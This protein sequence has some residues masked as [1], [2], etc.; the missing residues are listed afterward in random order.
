MRWQSGV[1][2]A[3]QV[4]EGSVA[5]RVKKSSNRLAAMVAVALLVALLSAISGYAAKPVPVHGGPYVGTRAETITLDGSGSTADPGRTIVE[6]KWKVDGAEVYKGPHPTYDLVLSGYSLGDHGVKLEV[7]DNNGEKKDATTTLTVNNAPPVAE[8][9]GPYSGTQADTATLDSAGSTDPDGTIVNYEWKID[10]NQVYSGSNPTYGLDLGGYSKGGHTVTLIVTDDDGTTD[11][12]TAT[13]TV[14]NGPPVANDDSDTTPEDTPATTNVVTNDTDVDGTVVASTVAIVSGPSNGSVVS[15]G[16]GTV[17]Y[18][19]NENFNGSDAYTYT[20]QDN[21]GATSN[22]ATMTITVGP[23]NDAPVAQDD[24]YSTNEDTQLNITAPGVL[25]NDS[26]V[27]G[28]SPTA[29]LDTT[30][31]NGTLTLNN[32]GSFTYAPNS[33]FDATDTFTYHASD[34]TADSNVATVAI[35]VEPSNDLP[36]ANDDSDTTPEDTPVTTNVVA[37]DT[38]VDGTVVASTVAIA[39]G[40]SNG[41]VVNNGDGTVTYTPNTNFTG[42]DAYTYTLRDNNGVPSNAAT[43]TITVGPVND[44]PI[45]NDDMVLTNEDTPLPIEVTLNDNDL[46]GT[47]DPATIMIDDAPVSGAVQVAGDGTVTYTPDPDFS[48]I[49]LFTYTV[50]D[51]QGAAS[52][53]AMVMVT[54]VEGNDPPIAE[55]DLATTDAGV[56]VSIAVLAND[57]DPDGSLNPGIVTTVSEPK[58]G[59]T[60]VNPDGT[61]T[62]ISVAGFVG[63]D[64]FTYRVEDAHQAIS[65]EATVTVEI[66]EMIGGGGTE[67]PVQEVMPSVRFIKRDTNGI[68]SFVLSEPEEEEGSYYIHILTVD[69]TVLEELALSADIQPAEIRAG[70]PLEVGLE[71]SE[72]ERR[73]R[74]W[75]WIRVTRPDLDESAGGGGAAGAGYSFSGRHVNDLYWLEIDTS[76]LPPGRYNFWIIYG[77]G[78]T[79]LVPSLIRNNDGAPSNVTTVAK[80]V[81]SV[82][83]TPIAYDDT[84]LTDE[85]TSLP[86]QVTLNDDD[87]DGTIDPATIIIADAPVSGTVQVA[88]DGTITYS[89]NADFSG[90]DQFTYTVKDN[91]GATSNVAMVMVTVVGVN[92]SPI[93]EDDLATTK[94]GVPVSIAVLSNDSDPDSSLVP[95]TVTTLSE[96]ESGT[97]TVNWD[98]TITYTSVEGFVGTDQFT[99]RVEDAHDAISNEA[100]VTVEV[101]EVTG[102]GG[103]ELAVQEPISSVGFLNND[104]DDISSLVLS[105]PKNEEASYH[106]HILTVDS[107]VLEELALSADI[108]PTEIRAGAPLEVGL[109]F[110]EEERRTRGWPWIRVT[111]PDLA[112]SVGGGGTAAAGYAFSGRFANGLYWLEI[113]TSDLTLGRYNFWIVYGEG[114]TLLVPIL[115]L[116]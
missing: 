109:E 35:T 85:N 42:S 46:D 45:A 44:T 61:I 23:V 92:A 95:E 13:L 96:P 14:E 106:I 27:D 2:F 37:N 100:A 15:N 38:D 69:S 16:D 54:V 41:S 110:S 29:V 47:I 107:T 90:I 48:G 73:T 56:P 31:S 93:A 57:S 26:D 10:G 108:Q 70:A 24:A 34:G 72:E 75:P 40:P 12:D 84:V 80:A 19:A 25:A 114:K 30:T 94:S 39:G 63:T 104:T 82:N 83:D 52:N 89:P 3:G 112:E 43:V 76:G 28:D 60:T 86:I 9:N 20:V 99:Y 105:V 51:N 64:Q 88:G 18:T 50:K 68:S 49:D 8:A 1:C 91:E 33:N 5:K 113:D 78:K 115:V 62:Y 6:Y 71:F 66:F 77:E 36:V 67:L 116:P 17:T 98:G 111:R 79:L 11:D 81:G 74:G 21:D 87:P 4:R 7:K 58:S 59:T 103:T 65:N 102:G 53:V 22:V 97:A 55:D 101:F 32:D